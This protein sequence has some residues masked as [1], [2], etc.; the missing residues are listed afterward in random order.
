M[1]HRLFLVLPLLSGALFGSVGV[2]V[3]KLYEFGMDN[4]TILTSRI[5]AAAFILLVGLWIYDKTLLKI[6]WPDLW[7]FAG[8]GILGMLAL[9][10]CYNESIQRLTLSFAAV[11]LSMA[12]I[13]VMILAAI[14]FK[15]KITLYKTG[16]I[17]LALLGCFLAS[18]ILD[19]L[20]QIRWSA[21]GVL[22][23]LGSAFFYALYSIFSKKAMER[24]YNVYTVI[25]YSLLMALI[26]LLPLADWGKLASFVAAA[27]AENSAFLLLH[28]LCTSVLPYLLYTA[29]LNRV[30]TSIAAILASSGEPAAALLFGVAFF[31]EMPTVIAASGVLIVIVAIALIF[32]PDRR[33][34]WPGSKLA[35]LGRNLSGSWRNRQ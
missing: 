27:P 10:L 17:F 3:R 25:F 16:L 26:I 20:G 6:R 30:D 24:K 7:L 11:L 32:R 14:F 23:G 4:S 19:D 1:R 28:A 29:A 8:T 35:R 9:N 2:F 5:F 33:N 34:T 13:F 15:E 22:F 31:S 12:P 21:A 18:G